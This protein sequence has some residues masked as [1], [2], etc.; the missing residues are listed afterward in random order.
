MQDYS[1]SKNYTDAVHVQALHVADSPKRRI[2]IIINK[3][4]AQGLIDTGADISVVSEKFA[5]NFPEDRCPW[6]GPNVKLADGSAIRPKFGLKIEVLLQDKKA[7]STALIMKIPK[8]DML[9]G[10]DILDQLGDTWIKLLENPIDETTPQQV[11]LLLQQD[12]VIPAKSSARV[13]VDTE[14]KMEIEKKSWVVEPSTQ[15]FINK[16]VSLGHSII[17]SLDQIIVANLTIQTQVLP[18]GTNLARIEELVTEINA[19][20]IDPTSSSA[21]EEITER[22]NP[23]L[24]LENKNKMISMLLTHRDCFAR[25]SEDLGHCKT[26]S[27]AINTGEEKPIHQAPYPSTFKQRANIQDQVDDMLNDGVIEPFCSF[28]SSSVIL[29]KKKEGYFRFC[30]DYRKL[31]I[32]S[33][34]DVYPFPR[35]DDALGLAQTQFYSIMN[36]QSG[37]WQ[38]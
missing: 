16:G 18:A 30:T 4:P 10:N 8:S 15:L 12:V 17:T 7:Q 37:F 6:N 34:K 36:M 14:P 5:K 20:T 11:K 35:I 25:G 21:E 22:I 24:P 23:E 28:W 9:I 33:V 2:D 29:V 26:L 19:V 31:N 1:T 3:K 13:V 38:I 27:H 32:I